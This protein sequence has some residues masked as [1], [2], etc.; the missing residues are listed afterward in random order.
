VLE[1]LPLLDFEPDIIHC[2]DWTTGLIP[3]LRELEYADKQPSHPASKAGTYFCINNLAMQGTFEREI[4]PHIGLPHRVFQNVQGVELHGKV[5][6]LKAGAEFATIVGTSSP[7]MVERIQEVDRGYGLEETFR[8]RGKELVGVTNGI[9]YHTWDPSNDPLLPQQFSQ[10]DRDLAGK[11]K[12]KTALQASLSLDNGPRIP[13]AVVIGRFDA[14]SG[15]DLLAE[16][17]TPVLERNVEVVLMGNGRPEILDRLRTTETT[18][19]G[20]CRLIEGYHVGTAHTLLGGAD[21]MIMPSHYHPS[22]AL[23]AIA[24]RYGVVPLAYANSGLEDT[25]V[26]VQQDPRRGTGFV[27]PSYNGDSLLEGFDAARKLYKDGAAWRSL[28][29]RCLRQDFS[30]QA[31]A[32]SYLKAY[33]RVTRR[34]RAKRAV[35]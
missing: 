28:V 7:H 16:V 1:S 3:L 19:A 32:R 2:M 13:V 11:R 17:L 25:I 8:R 18:F 12:C 34:V 29:L 5:N 23:C 14:D 4:L 31:T 27:F 21:L 26:D 22:N 24:L 6:F 10:R 33:R 35:T 30:W 20:R 9:D 15:F